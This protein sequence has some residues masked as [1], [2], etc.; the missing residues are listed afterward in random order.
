M[1]INAKEGSVQTD[2]LVL[3]GKNTW[4]T[5]EDAEKVQITTEKQTKGD[6]PEYVEK[7]T[8]H[9]KTDKSWENPCLWAWSAPD[10]TNAFT[11]W[12]GETLEEDAV[13]SYEAPEEA[14]NEEEAA[15]GGPETA[16]EPAVESSEAASSVDAGDTR[17]AEVQ[18]SNETPIIIAV[19]IIAAAAVAAGVIIIRKKRQ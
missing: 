6:I 8:V 14:V 17:P 19:I 4:V 12:P 9:V 13:V 1:I 15:A 2:E 3:D 16:Q 18:K 7:F 11:A 10:G 5:V